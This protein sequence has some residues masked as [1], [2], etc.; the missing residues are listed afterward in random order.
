MKPSTIVRV[1]IGL[2]AAVALSLSPVMAGEAQAA[3]GRSAVAQAS[4]VDKSSSAHKPSGKDQRGRHAR[5][6]RPVEPWTGMVQ[7]CSGTFNRSN[8]KDLI[9][10]GIWAPEFEP[11]L[12]PFGRA[13]TFFVY[14]GNTPVG[15]VEMPAQGDFGGIITLSNTYGSYVK[16]TQRIALY[17]SCGRLVAWDW[18]TLDWDW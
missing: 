18:I 15:W 12:T 4:S 2:A 3:D 13:G 10:G 7:R 17:D 9:W 8:H 6:C 5:H 14:V 11:T 1:G 16:G